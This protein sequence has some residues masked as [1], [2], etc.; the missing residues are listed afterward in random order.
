[1]QAVDDFL[2]VLGGL[3]E[4]RRAGYKIIDADTGEQPSL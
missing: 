1:M 4:V 2:F 3:R